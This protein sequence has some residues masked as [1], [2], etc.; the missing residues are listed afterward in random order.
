ML[1]SRRVQVGPSDVGFRGLQNA[2]RESS[3]RALT[4]DEIGA[5]VGAFAHAAKA[6]DPAL[7]APSTLLRHNPVT[8]AEARAFVPCGAVRA[9]YSSLGPPVYGSA[10]LTLT[11][12]L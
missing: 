7:S 4:L 12:H 5:L 3:C 9:P 10:T 2:G 6:R 8:S 1:G 11:Q